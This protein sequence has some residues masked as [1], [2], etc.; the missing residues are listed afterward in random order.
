MLL[1]VHEII[2]L[3]SY[4]LHS[5]TLRFI[6]VAWNCATFFLVYKN[7]KLQYLHKKIAYKV[8]IHVVP[9]RIGFLGENGITLVVLVDLISKREIIL[10]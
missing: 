3:V 10:I 2:T 9:G 1:K 5:A 7:S 8:T 6:F 4:K